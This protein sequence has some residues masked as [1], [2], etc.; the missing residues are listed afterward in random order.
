MVEEPDAGRGA[1]LFADDSG[2]SDDDVAVTRTVA[3]GGGGGGRPGELLLDIEM[4]PSLSLTC[5][6]CTA[7]RALS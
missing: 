5:T 3:D 2:D 7:C 6:A 1:F 4:T